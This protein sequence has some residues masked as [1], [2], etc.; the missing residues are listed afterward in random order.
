M[1]DRTKW[2]ARGVWDTEQDLIYWIDK[3]TQLP[4]LIIRQAFGHLCG[5]V[6][7]TSDNKFY[8][9]DY[10]SEFF[11]SLKVHGGVTFTGSLDFHVMIL[12]HKWW[13][14]FDCGHYYDLCPAYQVSV[15]A[16]NRMYKDIKYVKRQCRLLAKQIAK[17]GKK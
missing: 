5:Y 14:G 4:C 12:D 3:R 13:V 10:R 2:S 16:E 1:I 15:G 11:P 6:A 8:K 7:I 9:L 17:W